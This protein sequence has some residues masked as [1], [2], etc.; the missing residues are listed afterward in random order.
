[1]QNKIPE[2]ITIKSFTDLNAWK[3]GHVLVL[4]VYN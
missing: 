4:M 1:M 2:Y 3:E